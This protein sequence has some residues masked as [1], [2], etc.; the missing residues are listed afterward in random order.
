MA[1]RRMTLGACAALLVGAA[2]AAAIVQQAKL[3]APDQIGGDARLG[4]SVAISGNGD[5]ALVGGWTD[6]DDAGAAWVYA[7]TGTSWREVQKLTVTDESSGARFGS[8]V[9]LSADGNIAL[10]SGDE[11]TSGGAAW[12]FVRSPT[13]GVWSEQKKLTGVGGTSVALSGDGN[14]ALIGSYAAN[15]L[16]GAAYVYTRSGTSW[17]QF[18]SQLVP[19]D[20]ASGGHAE[21]GISVALS[22]DGNTALIGGYED[23]VEVS[24]QSIG[25][26]WIFTRSAGGFTQLGSKLTANNE[27]S[28]DSSSFGTS[29][30]VSNDGGTALIGGPDDEPS[31]AA[32]VF[33]RSGSTYSQLTK[34][35]PGGATGPG[36]SFGDSVAL[37]ADGATA[38]IG[39]DSDGLLDVNDASPGAAWEFS[40][41]GSTFVPDGV[42]FVPSG[43]TGSNF[44]ASVA[45][46]GDANTALVGG[47]LD[48]GVYPSNDM[49]A[50]T[51]PGAA[52][53]YVSPPTASSIG[54]SSGPA[55]GGTSIVIVGTNFTGT[56]SVTIGGRPATFSV[57]SPEALIVKTPPGT[58]NAP[59][60]VTTAATSAT[61]GTFTYIPPAPVLTKFGES[62]KTWRLGSKL[63]TISRAKKPP[64]GTTFSFTLSEAATVQLTFKRGKQGAGTLKLSARAGKDKIVFDGRLS[65]KQKLKPGSYTLTAVA[66]LDGKSSEQSRLSFKIASG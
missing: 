24:G 23:G 29:V 13:T 11:N 8:A 36:G 42:K 49:G 3:T 50:P 31:G 62:H 60:V 17:S 32:W 59:I 6:N 54:P 4:D 51:F 30:A 22:G 5:A 26:A 56:I 18:G 64:T 20:E 10:I 58:G 39:D 55:A 25:A 46:S 2:P 1:I 40:Q 7:R 47:T 37:S 66:T 16:V 38:L 28:G 61:V 21:F 53:I 35:T 65:R 9:A 12:I 33:T 45:L 52:W 34:I 63:A 41:Q 14:T 43:D 19:N 27:S 15:S 44:G 57:G 48:G